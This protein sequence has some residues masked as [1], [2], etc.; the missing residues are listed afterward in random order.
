MESFAKTLP[1]G[2]KVLDVGS[3]D[4]NGNFKELFTEH[5][6]IGC[7][8]VAGKNV[9]VVQDDPMKLPFADGSFDVVISGNMFEHCVQPERMAAEINRVLKFGGLT[10]HTTPWV[11]HYHGEQHFKDYWR[12]SPDAFAWL[13]NGYTVIAN[14]FDG[15]DTFFIGRKD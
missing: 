9:D 5:E 10:C 11:I 7:D 8:V 13:F 4:I 15:I 14:R 1:P 3:A 6:Y 12:L 2:L